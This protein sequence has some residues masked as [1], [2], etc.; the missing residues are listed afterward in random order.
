MLEQYLQQM[1]EMRRTMTLPAKFK[2]CC[3]ED[4]VLSNGKKFNKI[5]KP[6][7]VKKGIIKQCFSNCLEAVLKHPDKLT[8]CE[9]YAS[10]IIPVHHAWLLYENQV[11]DPTWVGK[12][13]EDRNPEYMGVPFKIEYVVKI[14]KET[15]YYS[16][17]DNWTQGYPLFTNEHKIEKVYA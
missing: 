9:G 17:L 5:P 4:F 11:I 15:N 1:V 14:A 3:L 2:Y 16:V 8:Y 10:G 7:W 13:F 6:K 12:S